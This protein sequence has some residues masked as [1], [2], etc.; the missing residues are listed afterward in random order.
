M[1]GPR[2][3]IGT[4]ALAL[5]ASNAWWAYRLVDAGITQTYMRGTIDD[6]AEA[7]RQTLA[8]LPVVARPGISKAE[9]IA[10]AR[11]PGNATE[12]F[13]KEG[14]V[15]V[16]QLGLRFDDQGILIKAVD[17]PDKADP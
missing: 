6:T 7:L 8:L 17:G 12:P 4:L 10:V 3:A 13:E 16:G 11:L 9:V 15:W 1:L 14:F 5:V 2:A